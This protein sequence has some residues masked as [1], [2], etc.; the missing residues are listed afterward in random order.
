MSTIGAQLKCSAE[1]CDRACTAR[2]FCSTHYMRWYISKR[3]L[4]PKSEWGE[5]T[6]IPRESQSPNVGRNSIHDEPMTKRITIWI[7]A[8]TERDIE[9]ESRSRRITISQV[10][11]QRL[12]NTRQ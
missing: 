3:R 4:K 7:D 11:L 2:G 9:A 5:P 10:V 1:G 8:D 6:L 12:Q